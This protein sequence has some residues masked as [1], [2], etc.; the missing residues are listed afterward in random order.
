MYLLR[1]TLEIQKLGWAKWRHKDWWVI[2]FLEQALSPFIIMFQPF[3]SWAGSNIP[4]YSHV[5][6]DAPSR[7]IISWADWLW[8]FSII[9]FPQT[10]LLTLV[11]PAEVIGLAN[12]VTRWEQAVCNCIISAAL[13]TSTS[14]KS[15]RLTVMP[16]QGSGG[17]WKLKRG[18]RDDP[19]P[20]QPT[21]RPD[22]EEE[23]HK[24]GEHINWYARTD[25][26][27]QRQ[28]NKNSLKVIFKYLHAEKVPVRLKASENKAMHMAR[29]I[30]NSQI[31]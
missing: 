12:V 16:S 5:S 11:E 10:R 25:E 1:R 15:Q 19:D 20:H 26:W 22:Q 14:W 27:C 8:S 31:L 6:I 21:G 2:S 13:K 7:L 24:R 23:C 30:S 29:W 18:N 17:S 4:F 3:I 28:L 9:L